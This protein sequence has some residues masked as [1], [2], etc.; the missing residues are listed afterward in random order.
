MCAWCDLVSYQDWNRGG[1]SRH[2]LVSELMVFDRCSSVQDGRAPA[3]FEIV[4][5]GGM[6]RKKKKNKNFD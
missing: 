2:Q 4:I 3:K 5:V 1:F 6:R